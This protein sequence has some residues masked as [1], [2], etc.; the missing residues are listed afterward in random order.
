MAAHRF[1]SRN[2][3][4]TPPPADYGGHDS[5]FH[6]NAIYTTNGWNCE[7]RGSSRAR[8]RV[9]HMRNAPSAQRVTGSVHARSRMPSVCGTANQRSPTLTPLHPP[10]PPA[11]V[12]NVA[13]FI[14]GHED[15][16]Y[17]NDYVHTT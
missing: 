3:P 8:A 7:E 6:S 16:I 17:D 14:Q 13:G 11:P 2:P 5:L 1:L 4:A 15:L 10:R 9:Q 12:I